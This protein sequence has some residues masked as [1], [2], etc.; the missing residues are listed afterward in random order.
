MFCWQSKAFWRS[1]RRD[2]SAPGGEACGRQFV[3]G[4][5]VELLAWQTLNCLSAHVG[6]EHVSARERHRSVLTSDP[7]LG[8]DVQS[9]PAIVFAIV[10]ALPHAV[11]GA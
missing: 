6:D 2:R 9:R 8:S 10:F 4:R 7:Q 1:T 5:A 11:V 3:A